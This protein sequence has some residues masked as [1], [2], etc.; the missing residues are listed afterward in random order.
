MSPLSASSDSDA[1]AEV[2]T[3]V[4]TMPKR[5]SVILEYDGDGDGD[6]GDEDWLCCQ[7]QERSSVFDFAEDFASSVEEV[8]KSLTSWSPVNASTYL[9]EAELLD[10][11]AAAEE[12]SI[13]RCSPAPEEPALQ[14]WHDQLASRFGYGEQLSASA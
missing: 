9:T 7:E 1:C 6:C 11:A 8:R 10:S 3:V 5:V 14:L 4:I 13:F 12:Q 2:Q